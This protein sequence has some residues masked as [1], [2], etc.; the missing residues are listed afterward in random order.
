ML[1]IRRGG[2]SLRWAVSHYYGV[3]GSGKPSTVRETRVR[4]EPSSPKGVRPPYKKTESRLL[5][6]RV[7]KV[8]FRFELFDKIYITVD[9]LIVLRFLEILNH[10]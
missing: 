5:K 3:R 1:G 10:S 2:R 8:V 4:M 7:L 6:I 9:L